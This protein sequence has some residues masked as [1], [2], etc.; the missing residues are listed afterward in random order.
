MIETQG[1][2]KVARLVTFLGLGRYE[3]AEY[4]FQG[5]R[6]IKT[7]YVCHALAELVDPSDIAVLATE[8]AEQ[9]HGAALQEALRAGNFPAPRFV[10]IPAG[11]TPAELWTQFEVIKA[12]LRD[13]GGPVMLDITH[14]FRSQPF[15]AAAVTA[16]VHAVDE[17]LPD[18]RIGYAAYD[19]RNRETAVT[20]IWE[21]TEFVA[22]LDWSRALA[23]F[24]RT[25][26]AQ[27]A[28]RTTARLGRD[29]RKT[30][31]QG[32]KQGKEPNLKE[33][34]EAL[35][36]FGADLE[37]LRTGDLLIG[38][39]SAGSSAAR[40]LA[41]AKAA[42]EHVAR[43]A[44]PLADILHRVI[45][46]A[47]P[48]SNAGEDL[49]GDE[50]RKAVTALADLYLRLGRHIEAAA[51]VREGWVNLYASRTALVPASGDFDKDER[52]RAERRASE[53]NPTFR[54]VTDRRNDFLH[55]QYRAT[56][57][58]SAGVVETVGNL[59]KKL[60][61]AAEIACGG[62]FVNLSNHPS[63][64]WEEAQTRAAHALAERIEDVPFP[65]VPADADD[66]AIGTL[67]QERLA[68]VPPETTHALV[69]GEFTLTVELVRRLQGRGITCVAA[70]STRNVEEEADGRRVSSF[71][72]VRFRAYPE[73][74][75]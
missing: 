2:T 32:G 39:G 43:H 52:E 9:L 62:R 64:D 45:A 46:M 65:A 21:L 49:S 71:S 4:E 59:V 57:Q 15:F 53:S 60:K 13:A 8:E 68:R 37:T 38:R 42:R 24:L 5:Q 26:R 63:A 44:P 28:G 6:A 48:L 14:G 22:L 75:T 17:N 29:L 31:F 33:L 50:G 73:L 55:A 70:T 3:P 25:G 67:A 27:E 61:V 36:R 54:E 66:E 30:W 1:T 12:E 18:L 23:T 40:L 72:F 47:E 35:I 34:G 51:T 10:R 16:F 69:Q 19:A 74:G 20:P 41:A 56:A 7:P 11:Q 58:D